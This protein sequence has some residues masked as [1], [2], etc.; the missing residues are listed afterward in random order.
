MA[1]KLNPIL[2]LFWRMHMWVLRISGGR[3][4]DKIGK[5][6][7]LLLYTIGRKSGD[8]RTNALSYV[9][10]GSAYVVVAT[11][12]GADFHP[13]WYLNL[14]ARP[15]AQIEIQGKKSK[16]K[17]RQA[18][19]EEADELFSKFVEGDPSYAEY[20]ARTK[21]KIPVVVLEPNDE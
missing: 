3:A 9:P 21:R 18:K 12:A 7:V 14:S 15:E 8:T 6:S 17:W 20:K 16:V 2:K 13:S 5:L 11:N 19:G 10:Q 4:I 1:V